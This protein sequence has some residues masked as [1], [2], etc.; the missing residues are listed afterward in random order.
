M[1]LGHQTAHRKRPHPLPFPSTGTGSEGG[2][3]PAGSD[4]NI[5][6]TYLDFYFN[7]EGD[8]PLVVAREVERLTG[9]RFMRGPHDLRIEWSRPEEY[10]AILSKLHEILR[11]SKVMYRSETH[12]HE[13]PQNIPM[14]FWP[15]LNTATSSP[16]GDKE[17]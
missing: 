10:W 6:H 1:V 5:K 8:S 14:F 11:K 9:L 13:D 3:S 16:K 4:Q 7:S 17:H 15:P 2:S 12:T